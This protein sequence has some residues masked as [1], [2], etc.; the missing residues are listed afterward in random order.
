MTS[1]RSSSGTTTTVNA[2]SSTVFM[3]NGVFAE[4]SGAQVNQTFDNVTGNRLITISRY[5]A[6]C[7]CSRR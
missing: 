3:A 1:G 7:G 5:G 6:N 4:Y 2:L